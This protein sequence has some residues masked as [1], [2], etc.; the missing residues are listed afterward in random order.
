MLGLSGMGGQYDLE[1]QLIYQIYGADWSL[2]YEGISL[3]G[4]A[5]YSNNQ[6]LNPLVVSTGSYRARARAPVTRSP[7]RASLRLFRQVHSH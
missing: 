2:E 1:G 3:S 4:E 6:F 5:M 7:A